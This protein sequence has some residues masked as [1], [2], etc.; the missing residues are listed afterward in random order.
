MT[1]T[2]KLPSFQQFNTSAHDWSTEVIP[3]AKGNTYTVC[4]FTEPDPALRERLDETAECTQEGR[5]LNGKTPDAET[6]HSFN[7]LRKEYKNG[8]LIFT[9][10]IRMSLDEA[11]R[12]ASERESPSETDYSALLKWV[13]KSCGRNNASSAPSYLDQFHTLA[14]ATSET[15]DQFIGRVLSKAAASTRS[16]GGQASA[17][18]DRGN[19]VPC[20]QGPSREGLPFL[21]AKGALG[22]R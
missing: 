17:P 13:D 22:Y 2:M 14:M 7:R 8:Q 4:L 18:D 20:A 9:S 6:A 3:L 10:A 16:K 19:R 5:S 1:G 11:T 21:Q 12:Q 15:V